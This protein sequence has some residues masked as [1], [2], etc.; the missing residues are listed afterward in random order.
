MREDNGARKGYANDNSDNNNE[1]F[2]KGKDSV[3]GSG[4]GCCILWLCVQN[5]MGCQVLSLLCIIV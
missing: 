1:Y 2:T 5:D 4:G 3:V